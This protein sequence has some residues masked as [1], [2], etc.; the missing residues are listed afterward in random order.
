MLARPLS[1][2]GMHLTADDMPGGGRT[3]LFPGGLS[4]Q[5]S[6]FL[7]PWWGFPWPM[8]GCGELLLEG[9]DALRGQLRF[10]LFGFL[11]FAR[12]RFRL[13]RSERPA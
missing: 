8:L 13:A 10:A 2:T 12:M 11:P 3:E 6:W 9:E 4:L 1:E 5:P 7:T